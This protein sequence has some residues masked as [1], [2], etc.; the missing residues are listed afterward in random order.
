[1][2]FREGRSRLAFFLSFQPRSL[3]FFQRQENTAWGGLPRQHQYFEGPKLCDSQ[4]ADMPRYDM[5]PVLVQ[6]LLG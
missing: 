2:S 4:K 6:V 3:I 1:M 5:I